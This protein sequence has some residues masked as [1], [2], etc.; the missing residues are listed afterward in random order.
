MLFVVIYNYIKLEGKNDGEVQGVRYFQCPP[1]R[2]I[3]VK[4][5][6][7]VLLVCILT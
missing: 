4:P 1:E 3:F 2:G 6:Q 5:S 7:V